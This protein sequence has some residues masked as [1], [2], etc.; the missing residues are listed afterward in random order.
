MV[1]RFFEFILEKVKYEFGCVMLD[2][3]I[4]NWDKI[5][6]LIDLDD[7][8]TK[9]GESYGIQNDPHVTLLYGIESSVDIEDIKEIISK[10]DP[11]EIRVDSIDFFENDEFDVVKFSVANSS[12]LQKAH[13]LL[14]ELPNQNKFPDYNPHIT[15]GYVKKGMGKKYKKEFNRVLGTFKKVKYT[16]SGGQKYVFSLSE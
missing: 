12:K 1:K 6:S 9:E 16:E 4:K 3:P 13:D 10:I 8:Y 2:T 7:L 15:I 11:I 14:S 5:C